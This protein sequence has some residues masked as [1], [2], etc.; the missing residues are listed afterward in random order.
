VF[1]SRQPTV[2][3]LI[4]DDDPHYAELLAVLLGSDPRLSVVGHGAD[5]AQGV[6]LA[7][8]LRPDVVVMD[9]EM[10]TLDGIAAARRILTRLR[11]TRVVLA[12]GAADAGIGGRA[13]AVGAAAFIRK[14]SDPG[15]LIETVAAGARAAS[16]L[17]HRCALTAA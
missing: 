2:R 5:G 11:G 9:V 17:P 3:V 4:V 7:L 16:V 13:R 15:E 1:T 10:P 14:G 12:S 8:R 6:E